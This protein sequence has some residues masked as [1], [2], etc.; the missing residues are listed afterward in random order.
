MSLH[1]RFST[2]LHA[3]SSE[4]QLVIAGYAFAYA[5]F[6]ITGGRLGDRYSYRLLFIGGM[7][8]FTWR[9]PHAGWRAHRPS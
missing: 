9:R 7:G 5:A 1:P 3:S 6:L 8:L 2:S 4:L